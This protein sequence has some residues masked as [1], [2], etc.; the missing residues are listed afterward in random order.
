MPERRPEKPQKGDTERRTKLILG[1]RVNER[2]LDEMALL[3]HF[4]NRGRGLQSITDSYLNALTVIDEVFGN[5][6]HKIP[7][8]AEH[9]V[10][11]AAL[12][13]QRDEIMLGILRH[14]Q[15][16]YRDVIG[17][18]NRLALAIAN[19]EHKLK[20]IEQRPSIARSRGVNL[21]TGPTEVQ[22]PPHLESLL[23]A[24]KEL[25][26][27][28]FM[29]CVFTRNERAFRKFRDNAEEIIHL[30]K[31][32]QAPKQE[33]E[34]YARFMEAMELKHAIWKGKRMHK[35]G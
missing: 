7:S 28:L 13:G 2:S 22:L 24:R 17:R 11:L 23:D 16:F 4:L 19:A 27:F 34:A 5:Y 25:N 21:K 3:E 14:F 10:L 12:K 18:G 8:L 33:Y 1:K 9:P 31:V 26:E 30:L 15:S 32:T 6:A 20:E 35:T 29:D